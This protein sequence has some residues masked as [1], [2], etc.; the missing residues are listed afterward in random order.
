[1]AKT[2]QDLINRN[3]DNHRPLV[4]SD[5][6]LKT[7]EIKGLLSTVSPIVWSIR[8]LLQSQLCCTSSIDKQTVGQFDE[9]KR[10]LKLLES[11]CHDDWKKLW[12]DFDANYDIAKEESSKLEDDKDLLALQTIRDFAEKMLNDLCA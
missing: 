12:Y 2:N 9:L 7:S 10:L 11:K 4:E 5:G 1:M 8:G 6:E 3:I